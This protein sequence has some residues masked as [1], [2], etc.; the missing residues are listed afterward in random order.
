VPLPLATSLL[1]A[2]L[3]H[4]FG[5]LGRV[6]QPVIPGFL[7]APRVIFPRHTKGGNS[8]RAHFFVILS[9]LCRPSAVILSAFHAILSTF[10]VILSVFHVILSVAKDPEK[11]ELSPCAAGFF[12]PLRMTQR[13]AQNDR[14]IRSA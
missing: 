1:P 9:A 2:A 8:R 6:S 4:G 12:A 5:A 3:P 14:K 10:H 13:C 7:V 11:K